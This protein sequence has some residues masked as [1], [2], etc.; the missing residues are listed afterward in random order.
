MLN[1]SKE[2]IKINCP[3]CD[4]IN[5]VTIK[6]IIIKY[7]LICRGCKNNIKLEDHFNTY[8][9]ALFSIQKTFEE[10]KTKFGKITIKF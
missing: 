7:V 4:F 8:K 9:K 5:Y 6:Q 2:K 1:L 3:S 10:L